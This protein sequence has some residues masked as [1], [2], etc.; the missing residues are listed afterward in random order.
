MKHNR[1]YRMRAFADFDPSDAVF[2]FPIALIGEY[3]LIEEK[4]QFGRKKVLIY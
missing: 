3:N 4:Y 1:F 2:D